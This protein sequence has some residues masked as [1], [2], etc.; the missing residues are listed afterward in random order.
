MSKMPKGDNFNQEVSHA[1]NLF[2]VICALSFVSAFAQANSEEVAIVRAIL[3]SAGKKDITVESIT[4]TDESGRITFLDLSNKES[5]IAGIKYLPPEIGKLTK[6]TALLL[7]K[8]NIPSLPD[9]IGQLTSLTKLDVQYNDL[10]D[11]PG[12]IGKLSSLEHF[13]ARYN[14]LTSLPPDFYYLTKLKLLQLWGNQFKTLSEE[15][16]KLVSLKE[17]YIMHNKLVDLPKN[18]MK[19]KALSYIDFQDNS[20]CNPSRELLVWL[21]KK[22]TQ[23]KSQQNCNQ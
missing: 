19:M 13:D 8:N 20:I 9:E 5:E 17:L 14:Q 16:I 6:L 11:L 2:F 23:W 18:I 12:A 3:D 10:T 4:K 1:K 22:D 15:I 21:K 7:G